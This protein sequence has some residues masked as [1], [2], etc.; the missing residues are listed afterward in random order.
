MQSKSKKKSASVA[1]LL[2]VG[3]VRII[4]IGLSLAANSLISLNQVRADGQWSVPQRILPYAG[5]VRFAINPLNK[6]VTYVTDSS[7]YGVLTGNEGSGWLTGAFSKLGN[8]SPA[9][10]QNPS[11]AFSNFGDEFVVWGARN[12]NGQFNVLFSRLA[13]QQVANPGIPRNLTKEIYGS[14]SHVTGVPVVGYSEQQKK[15]FVVYAENPDPDVPGD[16]PIWEVE[17]ADFGA[18]WSSPQQLGG[19]QGY[20]PAFPAMIVD[21]AGKP[22]VFYGAMASDDSHSWLY[23]RVRDA[24]GNWSA[25]Q[26]ISGG[27][28][29]R[30]F[31]PRPALASTGDIWLIWASD[32]PAGVAVDKEATVARWNA[33]SGQWQHWNN[34]SQGAGVGFAAITVAEDGTIWVAWT[35]I[36]DHNLSNW[37]VD[38]TTSRDNGSTWTPVTRIFKNGDWQ[39]LRS[40]DIALAASKQ[41]IYLG[42]CAESTDPNHIQQASLFL[43]TIPQVAY[44]PIPTAT[45]VP[46]T[47]TATSLPPT[48]TVTAPAIAPINPTSTP[49][50]A[51]TIS[52]QAGASTNI[53]PNQAQAASPTP[54][55]GNQPAPPAIATST[56]PADIVQA[57]SYAQNQANAAK[58]PVLI[59]VPIAMQ[60]STGQGPAL[61]LPTATATPI[62]T[63]ATINPTA[64][65]ASTTISAAPTIVAP[66]PT[67]PAVTPN[68]ATAQAQGSTPTNNGSNPIPPIAFA[69]T[70]FALALAGKGAINLWGLLIRK[71]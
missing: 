27:N 45:A 20:A 15:L 4:V 1:K 52:N 70:P 36:A 34:V 28:R 65:P 18:K 13:P 58:T 49:T 66:E 12:A 63:T 39:W 21:Q 19:L 42:I 62:A 43:S 40:F 53:P 31:R 23:E 41:Q 35:N 2:K 60:T 7:G 59:Q 33:S 55:I 57:T 48:P 67:Q 29:S 22:H 54:V 64:A 25:P 26:E 10:D 14:D 61:V 38:F 46:P 37:H 56:L 24:A 9:L 71:P 11:V 5:L 50:S 17:S 51:P 44:G 3:I 8:D 32:P 30:I 68:Q 6:N 47:A 69:I 16:R